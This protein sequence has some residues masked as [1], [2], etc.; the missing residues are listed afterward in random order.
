MPGLSLVS[1][2]ALVL[3]MFLVGLEFDPRLLRG[4]V[5]SSLFV[6]QSS[7]VVPFVSGAALAVALYPRFGP[8]GVPVLT[9]ALFLGAAMSVTAFPVLARILAERGLVRTEVGAVSLACAAVDDVTAWCLLAFV[10]AVAESTGVAGAAL[11]AA[12]TLGY[13]AVLAFGVRP[14]LGPLGPKA[15]ADLSP[16]LLAGLFVALFA[17][18]FVT[19]W[20]G[21]HALFG[22]FLFGA[23]LPREGGLGHALA[24]RLEDVV[25]VV[26]LP[27][28]FAFSGL[29]TKIGLLDDAESWLACA[30][31]VA[32]AVGGKLGGGTFAA[33]LTGASWREATTI[34]VLMNTRGL[35]ELVVLNVGL[36]LGVISD[37]VFAMM[38]VMALVTTWM[39]SPLV[40]RL[41]P[42][43]RVEREL[44]AL[45]GP[46][47]P[48]V[49][50]VCVSDPA[51]APA[52]L[53][54]A[55]A[56]HRA[57]GGEVLA[58]HVT[59]VDRPSSY[60]RDDGPPAGPGPLPA[61][62]AGAAARNLPLRALS[63]AAAEPVQELARVAAVKRAPLVLVGAQRS[64]LGGPAS[65]AVA[66]LLAALDQGVGVVSDRGLERVTR[67]VLASDDPAA[68]A[69][70]EQVARGVGLPVETGPARAGDLL[71]ATL[72][73]ADGALVPDAAAAVVYVR[74]AR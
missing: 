26:L 59:P 40:D 53:A 28:F 64:S 35:M 4:R 14:L 6:S 65:G 30:A 57:D 47:L 60:L 58:V 67:V 49:A 33:R 56:L 27:L 72:G 55:E 46:P 37:R 18:A 39:T 51:I 24:A 16:E 66:P 52:M 42:K 19:E 5:R 44:A 41:W 50:L 31:V 32:V 22:A 23:V 74:G 13:V 73:A 34:G 68:R 43:D 71:V 17:S 54:L 36:D 2:L 7:I 48:P 25:T 45:P 1:Q 61:L 9:F 63:F 38:V 8:P 69:F 10:V 70:A 62:R 11:T 3:F 21:V 20:I 29:R 12:L 15:G